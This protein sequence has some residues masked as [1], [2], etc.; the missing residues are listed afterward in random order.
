MQDNE[1]LQIHL[2]YVTR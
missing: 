2:R 1:I